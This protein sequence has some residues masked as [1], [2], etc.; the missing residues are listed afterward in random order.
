M[1]LH[2]I[3]IACEDL[4]ES[5]Q[6]HR[7]LFKLRQVSGI[8]DDPLHKVSVVLLSDSEGKVLIELVAPL[9]GRSPLYGLLK[10]GIHLYHLCY[11]VKNI[12]AALEEARRSNS[13]II[14]RPTPAKLYEGRRIAFIYTPDKYI[15]EFLEEEGERAV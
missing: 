13:L 14:S 7:M 2:H 9:T 8:V 1:R 3:G 4:E 10:R 12:D 11:L 5:I 15:V 6:R